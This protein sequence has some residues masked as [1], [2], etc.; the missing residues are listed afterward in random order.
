M[1]KILVVEDDEQLRKNIQEQL[2]LNDYEVRVASNGLKALDLLPSF[3]PDLIL[4]DVLMPEMDGIAFIRAVKSNKNYR[5]V[6]FIFLTAKVAQQDMFL[7][8]EEGAVDYLSKPFL[9]R[10]L[11]LK[12][13][14]ITRQRAEFILHNLQNSTEEESDFQFVKQF[15]PLLDGHFDD[16]SLTISK[17]AEAM[18]MSLSAFQRQIKTFFPTNF[19][20]L[21]KDYRLQKATHYLTQT[22]QNLQWIANRCGFSSLSYFSFC[23]K[24]AFKLSPLRF[25]MKSRL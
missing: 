6:P 9:H 25:R 23:F 15:W 8:L 16:S 12:V 13:N 18:N 22:D 1:A 10:E 17:A 3:Q 4:C 11:L 7:G 21:L 19:N 24:K 20:E 5:F 2:E 14:N